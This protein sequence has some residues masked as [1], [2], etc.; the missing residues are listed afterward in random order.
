M[1]GPSSGYAA[2]I[3]LLNAVTTTGAGTSKQFN[4]SI[5]YRTCQATVTGT[6]AVTA[7]V[8]IEVSNDN[9]GWILAGTIALSG[10]TTATDGF[11]IQATW[12]NIRANVTALSGTGAAVT[13]V[14]AV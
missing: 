4:H 1:Q 7:S 9:V 13:A 5:P 14:V 12:L 3:T 10:T 11:T 2:T 8:N 6:G